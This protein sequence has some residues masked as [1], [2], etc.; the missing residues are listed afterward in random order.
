VAGHR[1]GGNH[2]PVSDRTA[3]WGPEKRSHA[4]PTRRLSARRRRRRP[5]SSTTGPSGVIGADRFADALLDATGDER[6]RRLPLVGSVDQWVD[7]T[8]VLTHPERVKRLRSWYRELSEQPNG[9]SSD[10]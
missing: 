4:G 2:R 8:D 1:P 6:L 3:S 5:G 10:P 9:S 7:F